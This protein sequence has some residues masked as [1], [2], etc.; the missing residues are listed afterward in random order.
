[1]AYNITSL[2]TTEKENALYE[3]KMSICLRT[4]GLSFSVR[5]RKNVLLM[6][7]EVAMNFNE[8]FSQLSAEIKQLFDDLRVSPFDFYAVELI[9]PSEQVVWV[10]E[11]LYEEDKERQYLSTL[12]T[13]KMGQ[14]IYRDYH[15][16]VKAYAVYAADTTIMT[17][18]KV[19]LPKVF[20][21]CQHTA[22]VS[23]SLIE[24]SSSHPVVLLH[25]R[26]GRADVVA[27]STEGFLLGNT[28]D[29][30]DNNQLLYIALNVMKRLNLEM[31]DMELLICGQVDRSL[32]AL[33]QPYF[34][35][36]GLYNGS[37]V[38]YLN[39]DFQTYPTY[40][41]PLILQ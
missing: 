32:Y 41:N 14:G 21:M 5:S 9:V 20:I 12:T 7:G 22:M 15:P 36:V 29:A 26:E 37:P 10:P 27:F 1:M 34:P 2:V 40:R 33:L 3:K 11:S 18:F 16:L 31:P 4:N 35:S 8:N 13:L 30:A 39:P 28:Y 38:T 23:E 17:A 6:A 25:V 19:A 24:R